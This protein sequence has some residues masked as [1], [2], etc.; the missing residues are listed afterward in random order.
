MELQY[1]SRHL[2]LAKQ[3]GKTI[4]ANTKR[5]LKSSELMPKTFLRKGDPAS[6]ILEHSKAQD[7]DL[8]VAGQR[9]RKGLDAWGWDS[10]SQKLVHYSNS[11]IL[12]VRSDLE[13]KDDERDQM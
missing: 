10:V 11:S 4:L 3:K 7:I 8:I 2:D 9:G 1:L 5:I 12:F 13:D 6:E